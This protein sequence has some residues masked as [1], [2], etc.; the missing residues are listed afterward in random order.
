M[1]DFIVQ[2]ES[3]TQASDIELLFPLEVRSRI[4][5]HGS[6][7]A[8]SISMK[9]LKKLADRVN[10]NPYELL[11]ELVGRRVRVKIELAE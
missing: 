6:A 8:V 3:L 11:K 5:R 1:D 9:I 7:V 10:M 2:P 4:I